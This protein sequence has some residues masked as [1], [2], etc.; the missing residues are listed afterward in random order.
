MG[1]AERVAFGVMVLTIISVGIAIIFLFSW[2]VT[3]VIALPE[4]IEKY[5]QFC[6]DEGGISEQGYH[7]QCWFEEDTVYVEYQIKE[8]G[9]KLRLVK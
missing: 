9:G 8:L 2:L 3:S 6:E 4:R 7:E 1:L 5:T